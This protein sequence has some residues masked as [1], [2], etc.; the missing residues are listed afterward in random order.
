MQTGTAFEFG[1]IWNY[2]YVAVRHMP[3]K[4]TSDVELLFCGKIV[5]WKTTIYKW[6]LAIDTTY[7]VDKEFLKLVMDV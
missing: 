7:M 4:R 1:A 2:P 3:G 6:G 5:G